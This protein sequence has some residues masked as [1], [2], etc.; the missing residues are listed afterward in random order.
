MYDADA[1]PHR[2]CTDPRLLLDCVQNLPTGLHELMLVVSPGKL[3]VRND[4]DDNQRDNAVQT[5]MTVAPGDLQ[6]FH[7]GA[8]ASNPLRIGFGTREFKAMLSFAETTQTSI[9]LH[10]D[11]GGQP[12]ILVAEV[13]DGMPHERARVECVIASV[14]D[15][16]AAA[17]AIFGDDDLGFAPGF[18]GTGAGENVDAPMPE[19]GAG[20]PAGHGGAAG[21]AEG[22]APPPRPPPSNM[23]WYG[24][25]L[26]SG[27]HAG[28][29][30]GSQQI[31]TAPR[32]SSGPAADRAPSSNPSQP[33]APS[34]D[35]GGPPGGG[36]SVRPSHDRIGLDSVETVTPT[37]DG[38]HARARAA[39]APPAGMA[40]AMG[41]GHAA[42]D[43]HA[44]GRAPSAVGDQA[45]MA[46]HMAPALPASHAAA[47][48]PG[49]ELGPPTHGTA[50]TADAARGP[51]QP[52]TPPDTDDDE[53]AVGGTPPDS[54]SKR[55]C[56][57]GGFAQQFASRMPHAS[58]ATA[59]A[60]ATHGSDGANPSMLA[61]R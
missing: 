52:H 53:D 15:Q 61:P 51:S 18:D 6:E 45:P 43:A 12:V 57:E 31:G 55:L 41:G 27:A 50:A 28:D 3:V 17:A 29:P 4:V 59:A 30:Y 26:P 11:V 40:H 48:L 35:A 46:P 16:A 49:A 47:P 24:G 25:S 10:F 38:A 23:D 36:G 42:M 14:V 8:L 44:H 5:E 19:A 7:L 54:P 56:V 60:A 21:P 2:I 22:A 9:V 1:C 33:R 58:A 39:A 32:T 37:D 34:L 13:G 20:R